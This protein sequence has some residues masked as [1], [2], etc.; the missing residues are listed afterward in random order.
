MDHKE[1]TGEEEEQKRGL[2]FHFQGCAAAGVTNAIMSF[3]DVVTTVLG[4]G[5]VD[6]KQ[7]H[8]VHEGHVVFPA[9][10]KF[11]VVP[12]PCDL[13]FWGAADLTLQLDGFS[14]LRDF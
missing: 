13:D 10:V 4:T 11:T 14:L 6:G 3:T 8:G 9:F 2:T 1:P 7:C 5:L 12:E